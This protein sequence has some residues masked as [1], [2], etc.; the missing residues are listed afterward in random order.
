VL[1]KVVREKIKIKLEAKDVSP[2]ITACKPLNWLKNAL[3]VPGDLDLQ[4]CPNKGPY[5]SSA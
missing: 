5:G 1:Y 4:T 2:S 3:F